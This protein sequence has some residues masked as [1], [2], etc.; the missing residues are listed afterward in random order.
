MR[1]ALDYDGTWTADPQLWTSFVNEARRGGHTVTIVT[2]RT[3]KEVIDNPL[4]LPVVYC[5]YDQPK[6]KHFEADV[7]IDDMPWVI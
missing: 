6:R 3:P 1:I 4:N 2:L 5:G 7:W